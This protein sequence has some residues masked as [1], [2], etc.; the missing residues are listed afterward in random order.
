MQ[1]LRDGETEAPR[2]T[3]M[4]VTVTFSFQRSTTICIFNR[5]ERKFFKAKCSRA[6][7]T[8]MLRSSSPLFFYTRIHLKF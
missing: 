7:N 2:K 1:T 8:E 4:A 5:A 3:K 6:P